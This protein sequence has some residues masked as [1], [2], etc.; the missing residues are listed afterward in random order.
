MTALS[1]EQ[2]ELANYMSDLS[3]DAYCAGWMEGLE[4]QLWQAVAEGP[5]EYGRLLITAEHI[6]QLRELSVGCGGWITFEDDIGET[7]VAMEQ[8]EPRYQAWK[9]HTHSSHGSS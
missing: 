8:W 9:V 3:E 6:Q 5:K 1:Q 7:W 2:Q 4:Y